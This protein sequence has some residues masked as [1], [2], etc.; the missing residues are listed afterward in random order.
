MAMVMDGKL[1]HVSVTDFLADRVRIKANDIG[2]HL[3]DSII[4][5]AAEEL[6]LPANFQDFTSVV[7]LLSHN[8]YLA[9]PRTVDPA[10]ITSPDGSCVPGQCFIQL[11]GGGD[12]EDHE[13]QKKRM[14]EPSQAISSHLLLTQQKTLLVATACWQ[15]D[16][17]QYAAK[18]IAVCREAVYKHIVFVA[19][20]TGRMPA[21]EIMAALRNLASQVSSYYEAC[22]RRANEQLANFERRAS[23]IEDF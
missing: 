17:T 23:L 13:W 19:R 6:E 21:M 1:P 16:G 7:K 8:G 11:H 3:W 10:V 15:F 4:T 14:R 22:L 12:F 18:R 20:S 9:I 5:E 2:E